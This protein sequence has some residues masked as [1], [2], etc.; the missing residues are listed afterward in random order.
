MTALFVYWLCWNAGLGGLVLTA[1][2]LVVARVASPVRRLRIIEFALLVALVAPVLATAKLPWSWPLRWLP[3][4]PAAAAVDRGPVPAP[5]AAPPRITHIYTEYAAGRPM[6]SF[7]YDADGQPVDPS[8]LALSNGAAPTGAVDAAAASRPALTVARVLLGLQLGAMASLALW[9]GLGCLALRRLWR[10]S[11]RADAALLELLP[12]EARGERSSPVL[13]VRVSEE[14]PTA[15]AF[16]LGRWYILLPRDLVAS[17]RPEQVRFALAHEW[18]HLSGGD[19][20][21]WRLTRLVQFTSWFQPAYWWLR[22]QVRLDQDFLA[23]ADAAE[24]GSAVEFAEFLVACARGGDGRTLASALPLSSRP[25]DLARRVTMLLK[26]ERSLERRCPRSL[27]AAGAC[28]VAIALLA[29]ALVRLEAQE[30]PSNKTPSS[31]QPAAASQTDPQPP[32]ANTPAAA[33]PVAAAPVAQGEGETLTYHCRVLTKGT[34]API[35]AATV[36]VERRLSGDPRYPSGQMI[37]TTTH[38]T[39]AAGNYTVVIPAEQTRERYLYIELDVEHPQ[40]MAKRGFGYAMS[41]IRKNERLGERP[42][43]ETTKLAPAKAVTGRLL[44]PAGEPATNVKISGYQYPGEKPWDEIDGYAGSFFE[45]RTDGEGRFSLP[46]ATPGKGAFWFQPDD[47]APLGVV[48]PDERGDIGDVQLVEGFRV[49]GRVLDS[50][51]K[52]VAGVKVR[53]S[54][55]GG[56]RSAAAATFAGQSAASGGYNRSATTDANGEFELAPVEAGDYEF[57]MAE[58]EKTHGSVKF[59]GVFVHQRLTLKADSEALEFRARPTVNITVKNVNAAGEPKR[60]F[61]FTV[62]GSLAEGKGWFATQ[63]TRPENGVGVAEV[64]QGLEN[65]EIDV[66][67]NEHGIYQ[68]RRSPDAELQ[69][70][71]RLKLGKIEADVTGIEVVRYKAPVLLVKAVDAD[72]Q[73]IADFKAVAKLDPARQALVPE[74]APDYY[75]LFTKGLLCFETQQDGR[76]RSEQMLPDALWTVTVEKAGFTTDAQEVTLQ[77]GEEREVTFV[78]RLE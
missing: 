33:P 51:G 22:R 72:G 11:A 68:I 60:G 63:S 62:F 18:A 5:A 44:T 76:R 2:M 57:R 37:E 45:E 42:F 48:A 65:V 26:T 16:G 70:V 9:W 39:D 52:P 13:E 55:D 75:A 40:H 73:A 35:A 64:P 58:Y 56:D 21:T 20:W 78:L 8:S 15:C 61:E 49:K 47:A 66:S 28:V 54:G 12:W 14:A 24:T 46:I 36:R 17:G 1:G 10:R 38:T 29:A 31:D 53:A 34:D 41:M 6:G 74:G 67:D 59:P 71:R 25:S 30:A 19:L 69:P 43:F 27:Q 77:E 32:S 50:E 23:D 3:A 7:V 4:T